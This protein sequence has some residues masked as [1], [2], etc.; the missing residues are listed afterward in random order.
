MSIK[1]KNKP[2]ITIPNQQ[3]LTRIMVQWNNGSFFFRHFGPVYESLPRHYVEKIR[4]INFLI[5][6]VGKS[7][8]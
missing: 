1:Q 4:K 5:T 7:K 2:N 6:P 8:A 3:G